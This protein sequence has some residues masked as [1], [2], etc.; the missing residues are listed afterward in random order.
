MCIL[1]SARSLISGRS[2]IY[3][4]FEFLDPLHGEFGFVILRQE[5]THAGGQCPI[6]K[7]RPFSHWI[8]A[9][10][11]SLKVETRHFQYRQT[12][13][14]AEPVT[15]DLASVAI[16]AHSIKACHVHLTTRL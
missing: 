12:E 8:A 1:I 14:A 2:Q 11:E 6:G 15:H 13:L 16:R 5:K 3:G 7:F 4:I 10:A 9:R